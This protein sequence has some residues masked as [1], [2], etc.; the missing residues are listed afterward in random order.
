[1]PEIDG[2]AFLKRYHGNFPKTKTI[3]LLDYD[4]PIFAETVLRHGANFYIQK[5][6][7]PKFLTNIISELDNK[8]SFSGAV[9]NIDLLEYLQFILFTDQK[10]L[11]EITSRDEEK[12]KIYF[13]HGNVIHAECSEAR[14]EEAFYRCLLFEGGNFFELPWEDPPERSISAPGEFLLME[15]ARIKDESKGNVKEEDPI[16]FGTLSNTLMSVKQ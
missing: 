16:D 5:P 12:G 1:M 11:L 10:K 13:D 14:G 8:E 15:A 3:V 6:V 2:L 9:S 4:S 7:D